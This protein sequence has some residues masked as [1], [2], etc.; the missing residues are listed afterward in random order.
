MKEN[1]SHITH[2][3]GNVK[4]SR[5]FQQRLQ[6]KHLNRVLS[7]MCPMIS[8]SAAHLKSAY[9][10]TIFI[11]QGWLG[12]MKHIFWHLESVVEMKTTELGICSIRCLQKPVH[13]CHLWRMFIH[14]PSLC[15]SLTGI[16]DLISNCPKIPQGIMQQIVFIILSRM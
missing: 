10:G 6:R 14:I 2:L 7:Y 1:T 12:M 15:L 5:R 13:Q 16:K 4:K 11:V 9:T 3:G 8:V